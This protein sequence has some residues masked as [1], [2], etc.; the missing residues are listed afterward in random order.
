[1]KTKGKKTAATLPL[2]RGAL[3]ARKSTDPRSVWNQSQRILFAVAHQVRRAIRVKLDGHG[4]AEA[5][6]EELV[7]DAF[8]AV[9]AALPRFNPARR[10]SRPSC[11]A[12][13]DA[14]CGWWPA[15]A[16]LASAPSKCTAWT[17]PNARRV[18][19]A[20]TAACGAAKR[21]QPTAKS[22]RRSAASLAS[23]IACRVPI[24]VGW[25]CS[26]RRA[27]TTP[28]S[29]VV[30]VVGRRAC[31]AASIACLAASGPPFNRSSLRPAV[32]SAGPGR[33]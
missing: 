9:M 3:G 8:I 6:P 25:I 5:E 29:L 23:A 31:A 1:M 17:R 28:P 7:N 15:L 33:S 16:S 27:A 21:P 14:A 11:M 18:T 4:R 10:R 30:W 2:L 20:R 26:C 19:M 12:W 22:G 32:P 24:G 13:L